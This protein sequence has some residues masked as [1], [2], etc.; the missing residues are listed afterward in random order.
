MT[1]ITSCRNVSIEC[2][3][4]CLV[5]EEILYGLAKNIQLYCPKFSKK[6]YILLKISASRYSCNILNI[7]QVSFWIFLKKYII[8]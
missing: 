5:L 6:N 7:S 4:L 3:A 2:I 8:L 1:F